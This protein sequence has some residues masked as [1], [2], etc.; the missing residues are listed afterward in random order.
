MTHCGAHLGPLGLRFDGVRESSPLLLSATLA[1]AYVNV[2]PELGVCAPSADTADALAALAYAHI[3]A[4]VLAP[5][6]SGEDALGV[7]VAALWGISRSEDPRAFT[8]VR[9]A[10]AL[11]ARSYGAPGAPDPVGSANWVAAHICEL[12]DG[13]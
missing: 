3:Q 2:P 8:L 12:Y 10:S 13:L 1:A 9:H 6:C 11:V 4:S 7:L 5:R